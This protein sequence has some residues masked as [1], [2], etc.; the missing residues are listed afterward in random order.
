LNYLPENFRRFAF[1]RNFLADCLLCHDKPPLEFTGPR[2]KFFYLLTITHIIA[3]TEGAVKKICLI[4][5]GVMNGLQ[6]AA[7]GVFNFLIQ[8]C[9]SLDPSN[10]R[11]RIK[12]RVGSK[13]LT[14][15]QDQYSQAF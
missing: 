3:D 6:K 9:R 13:F 4:R 15:M 11:P 1:R 12:T 5:F 2:L 10:T 8:P 7:R 14:A